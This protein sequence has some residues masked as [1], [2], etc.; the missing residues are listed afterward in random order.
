MPNKQPIWMVRAGE[1]AYLVDDFLTKNLVAIGWNQVGD[2]TQLKD[3]ESLKAKLQAA[4][5]DYKTGQINKLPARFT[6]SASS[7]PPARK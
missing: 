2:L 6:A 7:L 4:Y 3:V 1:D 5:P